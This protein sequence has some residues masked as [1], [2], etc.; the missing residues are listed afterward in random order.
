M[1][2]CFKAAVPNLKLGVPPGVR[3]KSEGVHRRLKVDNENAI[4]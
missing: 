3:E 2:E 1:S 4:K